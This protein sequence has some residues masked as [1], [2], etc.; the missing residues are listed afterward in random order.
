MHLAD[1]LGHAVPAHSP[2]QAQLAS[3]PELPLSAQHC[4]LCG[5]ERSGKI[6]L[7]F[8]AALSLARQGKTVL[9]LCRR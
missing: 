8:H 7:L 4:L 9:L 6:S 2:L 1:F 3:L 5:P